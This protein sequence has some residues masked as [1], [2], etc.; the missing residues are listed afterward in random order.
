MRRS[1]RKKEAQ[2]ERAAGG[3]GH[4][5]D[6]SPSLQLQCL[7]PHVTAP[8]LLQS[9]GL[10]GLWVLPPLPLSTFPS[11]LPASLPPQASLHH[12]AWIWHHPSSGTTAVLKESRR[13]PRSLQSG[14]FLCAQL[15]RLRATAW[16]VA[17]QA[18][19]PVL[20]ILQARILGWIARPSPREYSQPRDGT[21][22]SYV[23]GI[24]R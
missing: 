14:I 7:A 2:G 15:C 21:H 12:L 18:P 13:S 9:S 5:G 11:S 23:T 24:G 19:L 10:A 16:T 22:M 1:R 4:G 3:R 20:G 17:Y 6:P 8:W